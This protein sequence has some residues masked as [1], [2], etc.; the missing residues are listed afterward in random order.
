MFTCMNQNMQNRSQKSCMPF[1]IRRLNMHMPDPFSFLKWKLT[2]AITQKP[3]KSILKL[4][5]VDD[6]RPV[7]L[8]KQKHA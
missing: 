2:F 4:H 7:A 5:M 8:F 6:S 1:R 3:S